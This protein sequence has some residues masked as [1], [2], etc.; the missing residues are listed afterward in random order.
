VVSEKEDE[1]VVD[2][3]A[4][5]KII[6]LRVNETRTLNKDIR[7]RQS[8]FFGHIIWKKQIGN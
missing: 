8:H 6:L 5:N 4:S 2:T 1:G 3:K 7:K